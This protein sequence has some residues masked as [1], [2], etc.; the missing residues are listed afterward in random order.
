MKTIREWLNDLPED[1]RVRAL[2]NTELERLEWK[3]H[4][5]EG[6]LE[7]A[8]ARAF[9]WS[10]TSE[11]HEFW[12]LVSQCRYAEAR[13]KLPKTIAQQLGVTEFPFII[14]DKRGN[15]IYVET[16][17]NGWERWEWNE[18]GEVTHHETGRG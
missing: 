9:T 8:L 18:S 13:L 10:D 7:G 5:L 12:S 2:R 14:K 16:E 3:H 4:N 17:Q 15:V 6:A 11:N 1:I